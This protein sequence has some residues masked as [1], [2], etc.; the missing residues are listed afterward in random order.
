MPK[1]Y[2]D[3]EYGALT[4][5][6]HELCRK[7]E[8]VMRPIVDECIEKGFDLRRAEHRITWEL[9]VMFLT[10]VIETRLGSC[11]HKRDPANP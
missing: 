1:L 8:D 2:D 5:E 9:G 10:K 6:G 11:R 7:V 3:D 4:E